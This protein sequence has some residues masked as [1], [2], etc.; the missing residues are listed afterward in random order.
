MIRDDQNDVWKQHFPTYHFSERDIAL[1]EYQVAA[2]ALES[3]E[4]V[5]LNAS[6]ITLVA[7]ATLGSLAVSST[8]KLSSKLA[9]VLPNYATPIVLLLVVTMFALISVK[10]FTD[11]QRAITFAS[12]KI[13]VLRR[14]LGLSYGRVHLVLPN[15]R[16]EGADQPLSIKLFPG[17][18][19]YA[20]YPFWIL[21]IISSCISF[22]LLAMLVK[23]VPLD[24]IS[25]G[26]LTLVVLLTVLWILIF[27]LIFRTSLL[28]THEN[29]RLLIT[30]RISKLINLPVAPNIEYLIYRANLATYET[31]RHKVSLENLIQLLVFIEDR[32]F[33]QHSGISYKGIGRGILS[34][35][36][37]KRRSGGSTIHQQLV[38][39]LFI[40][41]LSKTNRRKLVEILLAPWLDKA[42]DKRTVLE[43]YICS[44]RYENRCF[45]VMSAMNYFFGEVIHSPSKAQ[46][47]FLVERVSNI[48]KSLLA[49]KIV[50]TAKS[51]KE[52]G[53][54][55]KS[56]LIELSSIYKS[57]VNE[58]KIIDH[59]G[60]LERLVEQLNV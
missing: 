56:D 25:V 9:S 54:L 37:L 60:S 58:G 26:P 19:T 14:M 8:E 15:W 41:D 27:T 44:V 20:A 53:V 42:L 21:L 10:Y 36:K 12:R 40:L 16:V 57:L 29:L 30:Q 17:W 55:S 13:V 49:N 31:N 24:L 50:A 1:E 43:I 7:S 23:S 51:A 3:E 2:K 45:G 59:N 46:A 28:D 33:Y 4:R 34:L 35:F 18:F 39:T 11:R 32:E 52:K 48:R 22:L 6:N 38:R 5:F 47:F